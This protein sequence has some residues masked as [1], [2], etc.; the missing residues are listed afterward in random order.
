MLKTIFV[1]PTKKKQQQKNKSKTGM[2][3]ECS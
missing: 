3:D 1:T 2:M